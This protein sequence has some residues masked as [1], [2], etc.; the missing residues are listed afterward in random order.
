[1]DRGGGSGEMIR[2][3]V[4][5]VVLAFDVLLSIA[6]AV[7]IILPQLCIPLILDFLSTILLLVVIV[8]DGLFDARRTGLR[9]RAR[10]CSGT[11]SGCCCCRR[12]C[13]VW[14][15]LLAEVECDGVLE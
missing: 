10:L 13:C 5:N 3:S 8:D 6:D 14:L 1:M 12:C 11:R 7:A 4:S 2:V 15:L 9:G